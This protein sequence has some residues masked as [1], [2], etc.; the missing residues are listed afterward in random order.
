MEYKH[1]LGATINGPI[2]RRG[3]VASAQS[4]RVNANRLGLTNVDYRAQGYVTEVKDQVDFSFNWSSICLFVFTHGFCWK[5]LYCMLDAKMI[6]LSCFFRDTV[7]LAGPLALQAPLKDRC[8]R[9]RGGWCPSASSSWW[10]VPGHMARMAAAELGWRTPMITWSIKG[11][12]ALTL[13]PIIQQWVLLYI[14]SV[15]RCFSVIRSIWMCVFW[16]WFHQ[17]AQPCF[18]DRSSVVARISDYRFIPAGDE[19]ALAD[20]VATIGP[21]TVAID[22]DHPSF[23]FYSSGKIFTSLDSI[24]NLKI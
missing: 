11:W 4:L 1:L 2:N 14:E 12:R 16:I 17:D 3:K 21:I 5:W 7:G 23:L 19:Q 8:S 6:D 13:T 18:Y 20:A 24:Y 10:T 9:G 15:L 22:A